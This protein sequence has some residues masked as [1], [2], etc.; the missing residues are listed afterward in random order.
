MHCFTQLLPSGK[1][2]KLFISELSR[3]F[4]AAGEGSTLEG[5]AIKAALTLCSLTLQK[6]SRNS[7]EKHHVKCL[8]RRLQLWAEGNLHELM[9]EGRAIQQRPCNGCKQQDDKTLSEG[10][11]ANSFAKLMFAGNTKAALN[12]LSD[13][14]R[15]KCLLLDELIDTTG[16]TLR[17]ILMDKHPPCSSSS[18]RLFNF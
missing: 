5:I 17:D 11:F 18:C 16:K 8:E 15:G 14:P 2:G 13:H 3:L 7:K 12:L 9:L 6:P 10:R 1:F 4:R